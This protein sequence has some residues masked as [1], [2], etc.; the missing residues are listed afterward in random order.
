MEAERV[1]WRYWKI[2]LPPMTACHNNQPRHFWGRPSKRREKPQNHNDIIKKGHRTRK[3][4][5]SVN[6]I[7][8]V[9]L[10]SNDSELTLWKKLACYWIKFCKARAT[11]WMASA[12]PL[13]VT[14]EVQQQ[15][16]SYEWKGAL[17]HKCEAACLRQ[18][19]LIRHYGRKAHKIARY[20]F[21]RWQSIE[22]ISDDDFDGLFYTSKDEYPLKQVEP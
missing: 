1:R 3:Y 4:Q 12:A 17:F 18:W 14:L 11:Q 22:S 5:A 6:T 2:Q 13:L 15:W 21:V 19:I 7:L 16:V 8:T 9:T 20:F 10:S